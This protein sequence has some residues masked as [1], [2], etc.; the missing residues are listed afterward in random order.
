MPLELFELVLVVFKPIID[1]NPNTNTFDL[2]VMNI[3]YSVFALALLDPNVVIVISLEIVKYDLLETRI[4]IVLT[5][6]IVIEVHDKNEF[7]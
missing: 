7:E 2:L 5:Y 6:P 4:P 3:P 1:I